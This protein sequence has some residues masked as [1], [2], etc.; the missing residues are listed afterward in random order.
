MMEKKKILLAVSGGIAAYKAAPVASKLYQSGYEVK[1]ILTESAQKFITPLTFQTLTRQAVYTDTFEEKDPAVVSHIDIADWADL[2][3]IAPATANVI[4][5]LANGM[6]DDMLSTT[7][8]A[9]KAD[10]L[11]APAMN[12]NMFNHPAVIKNMETLASFGWRFIEPNEGLLACGWIGKGRLAEPEELI[13]AVHMYFNEK[14]DDQPFPLKGKKVMVT[15]G[16]TREELDPVRYFTN[17]SSGKMGYAIAA[18]A[19]NLGADVTLITGPTSLEVPSGVKVEKVIS[20]KDMFEKAISLYGKQDVVIKCAAVADYTPVTVHENK[21][22]K[23][24]DTWTI[25]LKKTDDIL[26][27][28]GKRKEHQILVGFAAETENLEDYAKDKLERKNLDMVVGNDVSKEGSG[29]G[30]DTNEIVMIKKD[31]SVRPLPI[32][33]KD[34]AAN[35]ILQEVMEMMKP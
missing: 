14:R 13:E 22:K 1:V 21:F 11:I 17:H 10:V 20:A 3:L 24:N 19:K 6:A 9:T 15:A 26:K 32:L 31:G 2:V 5:K 28:L 34:Q 8:L 30:S 33:S 25:E 7:L 18:A 16:P 29:F 4:G 35:E 27:E 12:V 23:K